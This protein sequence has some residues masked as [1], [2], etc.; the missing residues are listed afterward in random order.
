MKKGSVKYAAF[1]DLSDP[2]KIKCCKTDEL[3]ELRPGRRCF[4]FDP[5]SK[6]FVPKKD[7]GRVKMYEG[8]EYMCH[9]WILDIQGEYE[10]PLPHHLNRK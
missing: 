5:Q 4:H 7:Y 10:I 6:K 2:T 9:L 3:Y 1:K 8:K